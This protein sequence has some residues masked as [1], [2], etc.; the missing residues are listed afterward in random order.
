LI[1]PEASYALS[2]RVGRELSVFRGGVR[3]WRFPLTLEDS[4][5]S[6]PLAVAKRISEWGDIGPDAFHR[7]LTDWALRFS[8]GR[9]DAEQALPPFSKVRHLAAQITRERAASEGKSEKELLDLALSDN[10]RLVGELDDQR[11]EHAEILALAEED[12][13][14]LQHERDEAWA[15]AASLRARIEVIEAALR[16]QRQEDEAPI[17]DTLS[18]LGVWAEQNLGGR[19]VVLPRAIHVAKKSPFE[20]VAFVYRTLLAL[21]DKY[22]PMRRTGSTQAKSD[23]D[24]AWQELGLELTPSFAG[25]GAGQFGEEY[26]V[27]WE[28]GTRDLEMH[29]KG[30]NSRDP[31]Y[32]FRCYFFW[33]EAKQIAVVGAIPGHLTTNAS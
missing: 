7:E 12:V 1:S 31:R 10:G 16:R 18:E 33:D 4:G 23:C 22:V 17:P 19:V 11:A 3:S 26:R 13:R 27:K 9:S 5:F 29:L 25:S 30:R 20:D 15:A 24:S 8:A 2:D 32:G 21:R 28:G 6:H 14:K